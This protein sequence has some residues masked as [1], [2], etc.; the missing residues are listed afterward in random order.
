MIMDWVGTLEYPGSFVKRHVQQVAKEER[1][2]P[3]GKH[4]VNYK[5]Y[6]LYPSSARVFIYETYIFSFINKVFS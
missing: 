2:G 6:G 3:E 1:L 5:A 4:I